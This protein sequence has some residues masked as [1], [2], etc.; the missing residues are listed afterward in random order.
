MPKGHPG[1]SQTQL[2]NAGPGR[3]SWPHPAERVVGIAPVQAV[4]LQ[5]AQREEAIWSVRYDRVISPETL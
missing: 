4:G 2:G 5:A 1:H 3:Q